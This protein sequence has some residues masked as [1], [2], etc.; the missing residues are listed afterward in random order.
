ML[1]NAFG[2]EPYSAR[3][4]SWLKSERGQIEVGQ[5]CSRFLIARNPIALPPGTKAEL[6]ISV[7]DEVSQYTVVLTSGMCPGESRTLIDFY[8]EA[9]F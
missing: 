1:V 8:E 7:D 4:K 2:D 3:V 5:I 6:F 9:P